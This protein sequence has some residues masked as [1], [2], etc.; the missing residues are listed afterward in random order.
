MAAAKPNPSDG[1]M[2]TSARNSVDDDLDSLDRPG[3]GP[4]RRCFVTRRVDDKDALLRFVVGPNDTVCPDVAGKLPG[5]GLWLSAERDVVHTACVG[6]LFAKGFRAAV[7]VDADL[8]DRV[9]A[10]VAER[11]LGLL[12]LA[13]R[14]GALAAG[15]EQVRAMLTSGNA[16]ILVVARDAAAEGRRRLEKLDRA[17]P[18]VA[19]F[20]AVEMAQA[21]GREHVVYVAVAKGRMAKRIATEAGRLAGFRRAENEQLPGDVR[22]EMNGSR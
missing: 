21:L 8:T 15:Y 7:A 18:V 3:D 13:R 9:E 5:R 6:N 20:S 12:G 4:K 14:A 19:V 22:E 17:A 16:G 10:L 11:C 2:M 1:G